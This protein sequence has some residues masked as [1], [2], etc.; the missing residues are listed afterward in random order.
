MSFGGRR[1]RV[2]QLPTKTGGQM[3]LLSQILE[4]LGGGG[5]G[6]QGQ[7]AALQNL[8][9]ILQGTP[10]SFAA[11]EAPARRG[12]QEQTIPNILERF[13]GKGAGSSSG[14]QQTLAGAGRQLEEGLAQQRGTMQQNAVQQL[15]G[16]FLRQS[17][18]GLGTQTFENV[19]SPE[20]PGWL[21]QLLG[22]L[23]GGMGQFGGGVGQAAGGAA[24]RRFFG[25]S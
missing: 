20:Q 10:E 13:T 18:L 12:F 23:S 1:E 2:Q 17:Q 16:N 14:L 3:D 6:G 21:Q 24:G 25:G 9:G 4:S 19:M 22:S 8:L 11:F 5:L 15:L 7:Q